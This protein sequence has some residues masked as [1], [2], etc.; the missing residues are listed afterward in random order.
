MNK[1]GRT[2]ESGKLICMWVGAFICT[3]VTGIYVYIFYN[4]Y[5]EQMPEWNALAKETFVE[6]L[7]LEVQR[8]GDVVVP[9]IV[10]DSPEMKTLETPFK[11]SVTLA[12]KYGTHSYEISRVKFDNSLIKDTEQRMLLSYVLEEHPL[13]ADTL[14]TSWN[15]LLIRKSIKANTGIRLSTTD[16]LKKTSTVYSSDSV[17]V[18]QGDSLLSRYVG[19]RCEV[20]AT[21]F[22]SYDWWRVLK[23]WPPI[24]MLLLL[25]LCFFL[26]LL[27]YK[28][29]SSFLQQKLVRKETVVHI[30]EKR[31]IV[32][33]KMHLEEETRQTGLY[34]LSDGTILDSEKGI[35][36]N[37]ER[38]RQLRPQVIILLKLFLQSKNYRLTAEEIMK[39]LWQ[40]KGNPNQL[41]AA[42]HRL[43]ESLDGISFLVVEYKDEHYC[44]KMPH[45]IEES[46]NKR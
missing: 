35:L 7:N 39:E 22:V 38:M 15:S 14:N 13:N 20:E 21:G 12:S 37:G 29:V 33:R 5:K 32:E 1:K 43:R 31:I 44:L 27:Y 46:I 36:T 4:S 24:T 3:M 10:G 30:Q 18:L 19:F 34:E 41:Y 6:A 40:G 9:F 17:K 23:V 42:V 26:L 45:S 28:Q 11:S 2:A 16:L 25:W 8:R